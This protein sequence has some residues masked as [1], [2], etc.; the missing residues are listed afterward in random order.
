LN[1]PSDQNL[2]EKAGFDFLCLPVPDWCPPTLAQTLKFIQFFKEKCSKKLPVVVH[3]EGGIGRTG[4]MIAAYFISE[5]MGL[6]EAVKRVRSSQ[7][8][9]IETDEQISFLEEFEKKVK[10]F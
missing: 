6:M 8:A 2:Y 1:R 9:A 3:C 5:G 10:Q 4:T 7:P